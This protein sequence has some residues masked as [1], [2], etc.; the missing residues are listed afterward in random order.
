MELLLQYRT[1]ALPLADRSASLG[2]A[3]PI[4]PPLKSKRLAELFFFSSLTDIES[5]CCRRN[6]VGRSFRWTDGSLHPPPLAAGSPD[7]KAG[8]CPAP[9]RHQFMKMKMSRRYICYSMES[10]RV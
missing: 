7:H 10:L 5:L 9:A 8:V 1:T 6:C 4:R 2:E 3:C